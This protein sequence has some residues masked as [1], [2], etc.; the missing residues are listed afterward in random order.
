MPGRTIRLYL[1]DG[2][3]TGVMTAEIINWTGK[4][5]LAPRDKLD[6][7]ARREE[8]R[9]TGIYCLVGPDPESPGRDMAYFGEGDNV[10]ARLAQHSKDES[11]DFWTRCVA[12]ISKD[13]NLTKAHVRYLESRLVQMGQ[14]AGRAVLANNTAPP[15]PPLPESD[16]ADMDFFLEQVQMIFPV[17]GLGFL[18]PKPRVPESTE[19]GS[20][21]D[22]SPLFELSVVGAKATAREVDGEF[23][24]YKG[25]TARK[26]GTASWTAYKALRDQLVDEGL[27]IKSDDSDYY[28]FHEDFAFSSPSAGA[29][30]VNAGNLNGRINWKVKDTGETYQEWYEQKLGAAGVED[31][32]ES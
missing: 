10:M 31:N 25:S 1:A 26:Q 18:Q 32:S 5:I 21:E 20:T 19:S 8:A 11:K 16:I 29:A 14:Q 13:Q 6:E 4:V 2:M 30:V 3:P 22:A 27:L 7:V 15:I 9:R 24:V 23:I 28:V 17:L 12:V